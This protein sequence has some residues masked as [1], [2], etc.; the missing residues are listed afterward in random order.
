MYAL[1]D[2][3]VLRAWSYPDPRCGL[4][5]TWR[6]DDGMTWTYCHLSWIDPAVTAGARLSTGQLAGLVGHTGDASGPHLHLQADPQT[7]WPQRLAWFQGFAGTAFRW[8]DA[9]TAEAA[10]G[11]TFAVVGD[12]QTVGFTP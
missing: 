3:Y 2:G 10:S 1:E 11:P 12:G 7:I 4:G 9:P 5:F 6:G 8:Q